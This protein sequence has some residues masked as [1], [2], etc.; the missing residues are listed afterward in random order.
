MK[1]KIILPTILSLLLTPL[2]GKTRV[3]ADWKIVRVK[4]LFSFSLP[5]DFKI[6]NS[7]R[8]GS[9]AQIL[10]NKKFSFSFYYGRNPMLFDS[11]HVMDK[12]SLNLSGYKAKF[13][14]GK[15]ASVSALDTLLYF[16]IIRFDLKGKK[17]S[18]GFPLYLSMTLSSSKPFQE[19]FAKRIFNT[20]KIYE[21]D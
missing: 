8:I 5:N 17:D 7:K 10:K 3:A 14:Y 9:P 19:D 15:R 12:E 13:Y 16:G 4:D 18:F 1:F 21:L 2:Q 20:L 11:I 6:T